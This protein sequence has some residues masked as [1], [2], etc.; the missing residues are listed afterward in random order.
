MSKSEYAIQVI[1]D[2]AKDFEYAQGPDIFM[3]PA[4][5]QKESYDEWAL[6]AVLDIVERDPDCVRTLTMQQDMYENIKV[7]TYVSRQIKNAYLKA[8]EFVLDFLVAMEV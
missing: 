4:K 7:R 8:L 2:C 6:N 3:R 1:K 5:F